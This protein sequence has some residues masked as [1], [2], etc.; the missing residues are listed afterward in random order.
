MAVPASVSNALRSGVTKAVDLV[1]TNTP[2]VID[3]AKSYVSTA[4]GKPAPTNL[5]DFGKRGGENAV[6]T[7]EAL[8]RSGAHIDSLF[9]SIPLYGNETLMKF[10]DALFALQTKQ[11]SVANS[12]APGLGGS[13]YVEQLANSVKMMKVCRSLGIKPAALLDLI[14]IVREASEADIQNLQ[15][16][17]DV[18]STFRG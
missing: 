1:Q 13:T 17:I 2:A 6:L 3:A 14:I 15:M 16:Q 8:A 18:A 5:A 11:R 12:M 7:F 9:A 4:T 10:R